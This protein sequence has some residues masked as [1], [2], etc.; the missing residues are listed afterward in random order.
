MQ[1]QHLDKKFMGVTAW[2][3]SL[4]QKEPT[5]ERTS[6]VP[7]EAPP[8]WP[9]FSSRTHSH[10]MNATECLLACLSKALAASTWP[11]CLRLTPEEVKVR[12]PN[13]NAPQEDNSLCQVHVEYGN[14]QL[15]GV[16][17][18]QWSCSG[19]HSA[20]PVCLCRHQCKN[21]ENPTSFLWPSTGEQC[22]SKG[23]KLPWCLCP[24]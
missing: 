19:D 13:I 12:F 14:L 2:F 11:C 9:F 1:V 23:V 4:L 20:K 5:S 24:E 7:T 16:S 15:P 22:T 18:N 17:F 8:P 6:V 3:K 10:P 21:S